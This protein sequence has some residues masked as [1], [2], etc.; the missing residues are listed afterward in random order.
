MQIRRQ[1]KRNLKLAISLLVYLA[2][3]TRTCLRRMFGRK[4]DSCF[5]VLYYHSVL[6]QHRALFAGQMDTLLRY[7]LPIGANVKLSLS[8]GRRFAAVTFDD[9]FESLMDNA[10]PELQNRNIPCTIFVV[11]E[12]LGKAAN[13]EDIGETH[14]HER[15]MTV[16]QIRNVSSTLV[17]FG[18]HT[19]THPVLTAL[20]E[21]SAR[22]EIFE[23]R[24][25]LRELTGREISLFSFP[26]GAFNNH[27]IRLCREAGYERVFTTMPAPVRGHE[28][29]V[30]RTPAEPTDSKLEFR[31]KLSGAYRWIS[32]ASAL[33]ARARRFVDGVKAPGRQAIVAKMIDE[34][35]PS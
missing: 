24:S 13:W 11:T 18:A 21:Q 17:S 12:T 22:K 9:A 27:L 34:K 8:D 25:R 26:Y 32:L 15:I 19:L 30:G 3:C 14:G 5:V 28:F 6:P 33:K 10:L 4:C 16:D 31:L 23:S 2:D 29:V 1:S 20:D 35:R 7:A